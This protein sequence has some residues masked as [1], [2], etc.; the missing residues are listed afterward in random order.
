MSSILAA[1]RCLVKGQ[2][3]LEPL[4]AEAEGLGAPEVDAARL[5]PVD[6]YCS[7]CRLEKNQCV[8][9]P[10]LN[11]EIAGGTAPASYVRTEAEK[12]A[13]GYIEGS[14]SP[15]MTTCQPAQLPVTKPAIVVTCNVGIARM[16]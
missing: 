4:P 11:T 10:D 16:Q 7:A 6:A 12:T 2:L 15:I 9:A 14:S 3:P 1:D 8:K 13:D 5:P